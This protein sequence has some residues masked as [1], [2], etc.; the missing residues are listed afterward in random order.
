MQRQKYQNFPRLISEAVKVQRAWNEMLQ[1]PKINNCEP[2]MLYPAQIQKY[3]SENHMEP[4]ET[5]NSQS[6][7]KK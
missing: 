5:I 1:V 6:N 2:N 7:P 4:Q 3:N